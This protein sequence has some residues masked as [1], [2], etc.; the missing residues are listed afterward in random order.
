MTHTEPSANDL[1]RNVAL[2][3]IGFPIQWSNVNLF[4]PFTQ[5]L[6]PGGNQFQAM[7]NSSLLRAH[8][9]GYPVLMIKA[10][11]FIIMTPLLNND[12]ISNEVNSNV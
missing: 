6:Q 12:V 8:S 3:I 1:P 11:T 10:I 4:Y 5:E 2:D 7:S 9:D